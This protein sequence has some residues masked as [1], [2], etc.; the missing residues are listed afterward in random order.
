MYLVV[1]RHRLVGCRHV[2][3]FWNLGRVP[4]GNRKISPEVILE[5]FPIGIGKVIP[6]G[7]AEFKLFSGGMGVSIP[8][9]ILEN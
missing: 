3:I 8:E 9:I 5:F 7:I 4:R 2:G 1:G 6:E